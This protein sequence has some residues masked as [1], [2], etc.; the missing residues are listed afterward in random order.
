MQIGVD[1]LEINLDTI[2][3]TITDAS[4]RRVDLFALSEM[5]LI[6]YNP[7]I[8]SRSVIQEERSRA[9]DTTAIRVPNLN[10]GVIVEHTRCQMSTTNGRS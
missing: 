9:L 1:E 4:C 3:N 8:L 5:S 6:D 7:P 2:L 10:L